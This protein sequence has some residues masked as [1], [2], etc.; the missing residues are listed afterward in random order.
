MIAGLDLLVERLTMG[1]RILAE[2]EIIDAYGHLS[3]RV[4]DRPD[5]FVI[6]RAMSPALAV[7]DDFVVMSVDGEVVEGNG[8]PNQEWPI[9]ACVYRARPDVA[10]VLHSHSHL[11]RV[12]SLSPV[13]LRGV[14]M[15]ETLEWKDGLPIYRN[16]GLIRNVERGDKV[17]GLLGQ[18]SAMLLRGHGD[19][20]VGRDVVAA[21]MR[22][23]RL[24]QNAEVLNDV[25]AHGE[26]DYWSPEDAA[27]WG[28]PMQQAASP[29]AMAGLANRIWEY[30][31]A[32]VNGR[33]RKLLSEA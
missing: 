27:G 30:Y 25:I 17:A 9:H 32:R 19:V 12:F 26:P 33:L 31:E 24:K 22:A 15:G 10:S 2:Q 18:G 20:V 23:V 1:C 16:A 5:R 3:A 8:F 29:E 14:V 4:P 13:K 11:S 21:V 7:E 6:N 28:E